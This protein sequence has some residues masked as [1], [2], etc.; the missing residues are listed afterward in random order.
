[1]QQALPAFLCSP[2]SLQLSAAATM[3]L[4]GLFT[5]DRHFAQELGTEGERSRLALVAVAAP[6]VALVRLLW[7]TKHGDGSNRGVAVPWDQ[8]VCE[9][10]PARLPCAELRAGDT[11]AAWR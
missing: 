1:V 4:H 5:L 8:V 3:L 6:P 10:R 9:W 11:S 2:C 7:M